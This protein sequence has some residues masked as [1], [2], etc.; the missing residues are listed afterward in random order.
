MPA[1]SA[2]NLEPEESV[3]EETDTTKELQVDDALKLFQTALK[4]HAQGPQFFDEAADAYN[5]LFESEIFTYPESKTEYD[6]AE[7]Q[8]SAQ[9]PLVPAFDTVE[10]E[11]DGLGNSLPQALYLA[12]KNH[13][14]FILDRIQSR[15]RVAGVQDY[16][17]FEREDL[18][19]EARKALDE[20][21]AALDRDPSDA[22]LWRKTARV[23]A[24]LKSVRIKR[25]SLE[26][27]IEMDDDPAVVDVEPPSLAEALAGEQLREQLEV[28]YDGMALSHPS[29][30][31]FV[32]RGLP[33]IYRRHLDPAPFLPDP[34]T[35]LAPQGLPVQSAITRRH[36]IDVAG[37]SLA[38][39]GT[40]LVQFF[41]DQGP[42]ADS[43]HIRLPD[44]PVR[45]SKKKMEPGNGVSAFA[46]NTGTGVESGAVPREKTSEQAKVEIGSPSEQKLVVSES[47]TVLDNPRKERSISL[48]SRKRSQSAAG[49]TEQAEEDN[50]TDTKRSKRTRRRDTI[51]D[52][53][54]DSSTLL[55]TQLQ[56]YQAAD[57]NLF[58]TTKNIL[59]NLGVTDPV[60]LGRIA[61]VLDTCATCDE[62]TSKVHN[63]AAVDIRDSFVNFEEEN[64]KLFLSKKENTQP[65]L[66][67]FFEHTK[68]GSQSTY[69]APLFD[70][71][72]DLESLT[73]KVNEGWLTP[74]EVAYEW[75]RVIA[76][77]YAT[78]K[79][80][81]SLKTAVV[82]VI[83]HFDKC[84]Y[85]R[86]LYEA[87]Y[88]P[89][90]R[91][92]YP[93]D[94][95]AD[96]VTQMLFELHLD[97]YES[98]TN[99]N[100]VADE[101][102]C[103]E[104]KTRL[105]RWMDL[106]SQ[107]VRRVSHTHEEALS[108][109]FLWAAVSS[110][111]L[112]GIAP[113]EHTLACWENL[114]EYVTTVGSGDISLPNSKVMSEL[115]PSAAEREISKLTTMDFFIGL[116]QEDVSDPISVI[117]SLEPVLNPDSVYIPGGANPSAPN[118][119][120]DTDPEV[121]SKRPI[122]ECASQ[123]LR[124]LWK[125]LKASNID[126]RLFLWARLAEAYGKIK[127]TTK[128][129]SCYLRSIEMIMADFEQDSYLNTQQ[130]ARKALLATML[131]S[132]DDLLI[133]SL[134]MALNDNTAFDIIDESHLKSTSSALAKLCCL[135]HMA[136]M[137]EDE[138]RI[139]IVSSPSSG[140]SYTS[141]M[142]KLREMQ[143]RAWSLLYAVLKVGI[144]QDRQTFPKPE[145]DLADYLAAVHQV[146]GLRKW[147]K[148]SNR[149]F[150]KMM[151]AELLRQKNIEN[152]EDYL[153]QVLYDLHGLK[154][155]V[156][157][158]EVQ[159]HGCPAEKL[160]RRQAM[161]LVDKITV[162]ANRMSMKDLLK[163]DLKNTIDHM[164]QAIGSTK[165]TPQMIHNLRN[166]TEYLKKPIH[167]L[168]LYQ[169]LSGT[170]TVDAVTINS[171]ESE[172]AKHGWF[173]LLGMIA[174]TKFK[175]VDLNRRLTPG[176]TD[177]LRIGATFLRLQLQ[178]TP[179]RW[180][181]WFRLAECFDYELDEAV[182]W[183]ADKMNK[184][185][186]ELLKLQRHSIHCYT[187][188]LSHSRSW[189]IKRSPD[190][191]SDEDRETLAELYYKFGMRLYAS[192]RE[193]FAMEPFRHS[194]YERFCIDNTS[195]GT[196][197]KIIHEEMS[198]YKVW[199]YAAGLF[200]RAMAKKPKDWKNPY[201][202]AKC[203]WKMYQKPADS[204]DEKDRSN[205]P[206]VDRVIQALEKTV[207]VVSALPKPRHGQDP[208]LEP[209]YKILSI[210][211]KLV[212]RGDLEA[213]AGFDILQR[214]PYAPALG[215]NFTVKNSKEWETYMIKSLRHLRDKDKSNWQ[216]RLVIRHARVLFDDCDDDSRNGQLTE[217][218][219]GESYHLA[220]AKA[221]F[222]VLRE[223][224][225]TKT[226]VMNVWKCD[227]ERPGRHHVYTERYVRFMMKLLTVMDDRAN[228]EALLRRL[229]KKGADF[230]HFND[231]WQYSVMSYLGLL[232]R[233]YGVPH[234]EEDAFKNLSQEEFETAADRVN[235]W[236]NSK[237]AQDHPGLAAMKDATELKKLN[238]SLMKAAPIDDLIYDSYSW[239]FKE[240]GAL[241]QAHEPDAPS[242][243]LETKLQN[244][245][246]DQNVGTES[247]KREISGET[248]SS[249]PEQAAESMVLGSLR[250]T[251]APPEKMEKQQSSTG[252]AAPKARKVGIRRPDIMRKAEQVTVRAADNRV[253][254]ASLGV[255]GSKSRH[256][257]LSND[258]SN[259]PPKVAE[260]EEGSQ[261]GDGEHAVLDE[262]MDVEMKDGEEGDGDSEVGEGQAR[263]DA[264][265]GDTSST[266]GSIHDSADDE[267]DLSDVPADSEDDM[268]QPL[269]FP[270]LRRSADAPPASDADSGVEDA[271]D[272][273][274]S[275]TDA[276]E[277]RSESGGQQAG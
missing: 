196:Y 190:M 145:N 156:G 230:Y 189:L 17:L 81:E 96:V 9:L 277:A 168:R 153:G 128:Q 247:V 130:D 123:G 246:P 125:F 215:E 71:T 170:V 27:A 166:F 207:E 185:R 1:F 54:M 116:F 14:Q 67:T 187:L 234:I 100:N 212:V 89:G 32:S 157:V 56:P 37:R 47:P 23:A 127:Y 164:Q 38:D 195:A 106:A 231:L 169:A 147:C 177:D 113:R 142:T 121:D 205:Q 90:S 226:M 272:D 61:E 68:L 66:S 6:R 95:E 124:D 263:D 73:T 261:G 273:S 254:S 129:F 75:I 257:S 248:L 102:T 104:A 141:Y 143:V 267:S 85:E 201:M 122:T 35:H 236:A 118:G 240:V 29:M 223:G 105:R 70:E 53:A 233:S 39:L 91:S 155:G 19:N 49:L 31:P 275:N 79:W 58:Q 253:K 136:A 244:G 15:L 98:F 235:E 154:L 148:G 137:F 7:S 206:T 149:T 97:V 173:F 115:S 270:N 93:I 135:L 262:D 80:P 110:I 22:E 51:A 12:Y 210:V 78:S 18:V 76:H 202:L 59:E 183:T 28:L 268:Q 208:I 114:R 103:V 229:R 107:A 182:L 139:G 238:A 269:L 172:L 264:A 4:L 108:V 43:V 249:A 8:P 21:A 60:T 152:W 62:R 10:A 239:I 134:S 30:K 87:G 52:E 225:F 199:K 26:A 140:Q 5:A 209:H 11:A 112:A 111:T 126:L 131:K 25:Y 13:G 33:Q 83:S 194:D 266:P 92:N 57:Q 214:Q 86:L 20:F 101:A 55:S 48:P 192:S 167:P 40:S 69:D 64:A 222:A 16:S 191:V 228:M 171:P 109:R 216:H 65:G 159:D 24:F 84:L 50:G 260:E 200:R 221:A 74:Q 46:E 138:V 34:S 271:D 186:A 243:G 77:N 160:E 3:D 242:L 211:H 94:D 133:Q 197:K 193:P 36:E 250:A 218:N 158:W 72:R 117:D 245:A 265:D 198:D 132:L 217:K 180:D 146:L 119:K 2:I 42:S 88:G 41:M 232:R 99:P 227:A 274:S 44:E 181:A 174:L 151:R 276:G 179:D 150:L 255:S 251:S 163:S 213:Q 188:A 241:S 161:A 220:A 175:A 224:M 63:S 176:A 258:K 165:S 120:G 237:E 219:D 184:E 82:Q 203:L 204:L 259:P 45:G 178:F 256:G 144:T 162:L 252:D